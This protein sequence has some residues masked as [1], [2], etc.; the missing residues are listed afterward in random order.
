M[1]IVPV[2]LFRGL[3]AL[4]LSGLVSACSGLTVSEGLKPST[5]RMEGEQPSG[6]VGVY[7]RVAQEALDSRDYTTA[8]R[9]Y[10]TILDRTPGNL[11]AAKGIATAYARDGRIGQAVKAY[12]VAIAL[13]PDDQLVRENLASVLNSRLMPAA[14]VPKPKQILL[15]MDLS[16]SG[17]LEDVAPAAAAKKLSKAAFNA[18][19]AQINARPAATHTTIDAAQIALQLVAEAAII[20]ELGDIAPAAGNPFLLFYPPP[21][22]NLPIRT[23]SA[24]N[25][26]VGAMRE[27]PVMSR[28]EIAKIDQ[29]L[30]A[31]SQKRAN[32]ATVRPDPHPPND[33]AEIQYRVQLAA[34]RTSRHADRGVIIFQRILGQK[35]LGIEA[36]PL[37]ILERRRPNRNART[38]NFR[39]RTAALG[40][41]QVADTLCNSMRG[42]GHECLVIRHNAVTWQPI[43]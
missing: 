8:I 38:I 6:Q 32:T 41:R 10:G 11:A 12:E 7:L 42:L 28:T 30:R 27:A 33:A 39:I 4:V 3:T 34:Y 18:P 22:E 1:R 16:Y 13:A 19:G 29:N 40:S 9:F 5:A 20:E 15:S 25:T 37:E 21:P 14:G 23:V 26:D 43:A 31:L 2:R 17:T 35:M 36:P 24:S